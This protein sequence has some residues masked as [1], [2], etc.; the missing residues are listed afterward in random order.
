MWTALRH[1][2]INFTSDADRSVFVQVM[3][4]IRRAAFKAIAQPRLFISFLLRIILKCAIGDD[5]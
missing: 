2:A 1:D 4:T 5:L 3:L